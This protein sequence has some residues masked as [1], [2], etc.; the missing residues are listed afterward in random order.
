MKGCHWEAKWIQSWMPWQYKQLYLTE[1]IN[2]GDM[3]EYLN[4]CYGNSIVNLIGWINLGG[5]QLKCIWSTK[6]W[7]M[8]W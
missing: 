4:Q 5:D 1:C 8:D 6:S 2:D 3:H 7:W